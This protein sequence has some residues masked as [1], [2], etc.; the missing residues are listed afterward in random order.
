M[1]AVLLPWGVFEWRRAREA[2][3]NERVSRVVAAFASDL[4]RCRIPGGR[5]SDSLRNR[6]RR[7]GDRPAFARW[8]D[9]VARTDPDKDRRRLAL[10][11]L[12]TSLLGNPRA[13]ALLDSLSVARPDADWRK[14]IEFVR[15]SA[16]T[17]RGLRTLVQVGDSLGVRDWPGFFWILGD[18]D[19]QARGLR[20]RIDRGLGSRERNA[21]LRAMGWTRDTFWRVRLEQA[22]VDPTDWLCQASAARSLGD[23]GDS[24][25]TGLLGAAADSHWHPQVREAAAS[26]LER[27]AKRDVADLPDM[28]E[29]LYLHGLFLTEGPDLRSELFVD[30][31]LHLPPCDTLGSDELRKW[32]WNAVLHGWADGP[33]TETV[34]QTP[35]SSCAWG[36]GWL[37]GASRGEWGGELAWMDSGRVVVVDSTPVDAFLQ[38]RFGVLT[39]KAGG[40]FGAVG[41]LERIVA[42]PAGRPKRVPFLLLPGSGCSWWGTTD[43]GVILHCSHGYVRLDS[44]GRPHPWPPLG[45]GNPW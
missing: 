23:L 27:I 36:G 29:N 28:R 2:K 18:L 40:H 12:G 41:G 25:S 22:L 39:L 1:V 42:D 11:L 45:K 20:E 4:G 44:V 8:L 35:Q 33:T 17:P 26:A 5:L 24:R 13:D 21:F 6:I 32:S 43:G 38:T 34:R 19:T 3:E 16:G 9:S 7:S 15:M 10:D 30:T 14:E 31:L 37:L